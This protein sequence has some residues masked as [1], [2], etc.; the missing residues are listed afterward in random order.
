MT[1]EP[2]CLTY[3]SVVSRESIRL[4][5]MLAS[6][7]NLDV[8]Q[9]DV[10]GA[11][12]NAASS[13]K[14]FT[15][16]G[17]EFREFAGRR[18]VIRRAL[19]GT[20]SAAASWRSAISKVIQGL[21]FEMCR[22]DNDVWMRKGF[23]KAGEKVWEYVLIYS[24]DLLIVARNPGEIAAQVDQRRFDEGAHFL[25]RCRHWKVHVA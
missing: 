3:A 6:L 9:A 12:L 20:K 16:C 18:A 24:D 23:N 19:Y 10:E 7:N 14:L 2:K 21:G 1:G 8:L 4:A 17:P 11:Y 15:I 25:S 5:F 22:A 13:E